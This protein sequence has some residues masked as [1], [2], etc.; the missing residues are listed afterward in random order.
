MQT[1]TKEV[2]EELTE[3]KTTYTRQSEAFVGELRKLEER[4]IKDFD[5]LTRATNQ[6]QQTV[7]EHGVKLLGH[8]SQLSELYGRMKLAETE[9]QKLHATTTHLDTVKTDKVD[10][11]KARKKL[12]LKNLQQDVKLFKC[13]NHC[14]TLD[15]Q[16]LSR[17]PLGTCKCHMSQ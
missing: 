14:L 15:N 6:L 10:F 16:E 13:S 2:I 12:D 8:D 4:Q 11:I 3:L 7:N 9:I 17:L 1:H 5:R